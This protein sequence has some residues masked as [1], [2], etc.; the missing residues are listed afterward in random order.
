MKK[1]LLASS[2]LASAKM[3]FGP[4]DSMRGTTDR[5]TYAPETGQGHVASTNFADPM[6]GATMALAVTSVT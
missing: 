4:A 5:R 1:L 3:N 2:V 6:R